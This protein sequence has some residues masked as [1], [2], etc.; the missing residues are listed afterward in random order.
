MVNTPA[1]AAIAAECMREG[2][3]CSPMT[4]PKRNMAK[5]QKSITIRLPRRTLS[6][7]FLLKFPYSAA[8]ALG[9]AARLMSMREMQD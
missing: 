1:A 6:F 7:S 4:T 8:T 5:L 3:Q 9:T 2:C